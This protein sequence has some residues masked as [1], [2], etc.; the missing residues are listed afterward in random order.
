MDNTY[1]PSLKKNTYLV[2][3]IYISKGL[4]QIKNI[5]SQNN[6]F[7]IFSV[8]TGREQNKYTSITGGIS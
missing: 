4:F 8:H 6:T 2:K 7:Q 5:N 3:C 1:K